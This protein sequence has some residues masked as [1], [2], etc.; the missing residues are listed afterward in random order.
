MNK[1]KINKKEYILK[2]TLRALFIFEKITGTAFKFGLLHNEY[3][4][5]YSTL[6]ANNSDD[7]EMSFDEL[8]EI[9]DE[10]S[11]IF[12]QYKKWLIKEIE[13]QIQ[14]Q[15]KEDKEEDKK[16]IKKK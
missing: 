11:T 12:E 6:L 14:F 9:C 13:K 7:F 3:V 16:K 8:I 5:M 1:I 10:D 4:L 2:Y 15:D